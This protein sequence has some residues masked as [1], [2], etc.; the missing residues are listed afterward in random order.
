MRPAK[1]SE[2]GGSLPET[3]IVMGIVLVLLLG[4][5]DFGRA[6]YTYA[7]VAQL[8]RQGARWAIVRGAQCTQLDHCQAV[9]TDVQT[10][11]QGQSMGVMN[12]SSISVNA[13]WPPSG[14]P[15]GLSAKSPGCIV[16]V[17]VT[18][19]F[20]FVLPFMNTNFP[21]YSMSSTSQMVISQ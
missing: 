11:V 5:I 7:S 8:A 19:P 2:R 21:T 1:R 9:S 14:C 12:P 18:Y 16:V 13:T 3:A 17:T 15:A 20:Q 10:F 6:M 4:I